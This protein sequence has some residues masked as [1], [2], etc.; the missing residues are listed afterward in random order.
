MSIS[1]KGS[2]RARAIEWKWG[3]SSNDNVQLGV[4]FDFLD[5]PGTRMTRYLSFTDDAFD[6]SIKA[7]RNCGWQGED[8]D[9]LTGLDTNEVSLVVDYDRDDTNHEKGLRIQFVNSA[10]G[11]AM[12]TAMAPEEVKSFGQR[13]KGRVR[14]ADSAAGRSVGQ[15]PQRVADSDRPP[16]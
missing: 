14:A 5:H 6:H 2:Y 15:S 7:M 16:V 4:S 11:I 10:G 13:M 12:K 9:D 8:L 3:K 1:S